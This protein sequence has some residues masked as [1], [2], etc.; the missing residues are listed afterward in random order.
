MEVKII[1][2]AFLNK[3]SNKNISDL[4]TTGFEKHLESYK[5]D[6]KSSKE[7]PTHDLQTDSMTDYS[8]SSKDNQ[9]E[10][11]TPLENNNVKTSHDGNNESNTTSAIALEIIDA[12][13]IEIDALN[14]EPTDSNL[15]ILVSGTVNEEPEIPM[16]DA[17]I[18]NL[19][20]VIVDNQNTAQPTHNLGNITEILELI[21]P[22]QDENDDDLED[23]QLL[24]V[25]S[26][27]IIA[28][29]ILPTETKI[30]SEI[31]PPSLESFTSEE[32]TDKN[33]ISPEKTPP[34]S[35]YAKIDTQDELQISKPVDNTKI[36][37]TLGEV[38]QTPIESQ[39]SDVPNPAAVAQGR[40]SD[41]QSKNTK[42]LKSQPEEFSIIESVNVQP[43][44]DTKSTGKEMLS[45]FNQSKENILDEGMPKIQNSND[46]FESIVR[47]DTSTKIITDTQEV[48]ATTT[49]TPSEDIRSVSNQIKTAVENINNV[50]GKKITINLTPASLGRVEIEVTTQAGK[51]TSIK[52]EAAKPE[53]LVMLEKHS[54]MLQEALK[55][56][57]GGNDSSLSFNL[58]DGNNG[59][60]EQ[61][62]SSKN[63]EIIH[64]SNIKA[65]G[66]SDTTPSPST[67]IAPNI[68][69]VDGS[70]SKVDMEI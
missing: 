70:S 36:D 48:S 34:Y 25:S 8:S 31:I 4:N 7:T 54:Q 30:P 37:M 46:T 21:E 60:N 9:K 19:S 63:P 6:T 13:H 17:N 42:T 50:N 12:P 33:I 18:P 51:V 16:Q 1:Q 69:Q 15:E 68:Y 62:K 67:T 14:I 3:N 2:E 26:N 66:E 49:S 35:E 29:T 22:L 11:L 32:T 61:Q 45:D 20:K 5:T 23:T 55:E 65:N 57:T 38:Q 56:V 28:A 24:E 44:A 53:T 40:V 10:S 27:N 59:G 39:K 58:K 47:N 64:L 41:E 43:I 52:I